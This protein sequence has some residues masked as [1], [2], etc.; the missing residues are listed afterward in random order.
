MRRICFLLFICVFSF[1]ISGCRPDPRYCEEVPIFSYEEELAWY[2][3]ETS[4]VKHTG[5]INTSELSNTIKWDNEAIEQAAKE[6]PIKWD[7]TATYYDLT[8]KIWKIEFWSTRDT[9]G[10]PSYIY[11][12]VYMNDKGVTLFI[13]YGE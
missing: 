9:E 11:Q 3:E 2:Q 4:G 13:V 1:S 8:L 12:T 10:Y 6:C 5:F 7:N